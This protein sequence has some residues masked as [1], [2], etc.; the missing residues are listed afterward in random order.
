M[1]TAFPHFSLD[2][3]KLLVGTETQVFIWT[4]MATNN[5]VWSWAGEQFTFPRIIVAPWSAPGQGYGE[6]AEVLGQQGEV[7]NPGGRGDVLGEAV[8]GCHVEGW[9]R[10]EPG[11]GPRGRGL[12]AEVDPGAATLSPSVDI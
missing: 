6:G 4:E 8:P 9:P 7:R 12:V 5:K 2:Q 1:L 10:G 11:E 3:Y